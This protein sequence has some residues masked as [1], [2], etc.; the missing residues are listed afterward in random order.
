MS[1]ATIEELRAAM[2]GAQVFGKGQYIEEGQYLLETIKIFYKRTVIDGSAKESIICEFKV[3]ES[4]KPEVEIGSTRSYV[5]NL[6]NAG[7]LSRFKSCMLAL[8]GVD[9]D[10]KIPKDA[11]DATT[12]LYVALR[13]D[14]ERVRLGLP[15]N[16]MAGKRVRV[17]GMAG[18]SKKGGAVT[19]KKW[20][21]VTVKEAA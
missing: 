16:F 12:D 19:N 6:A 10:G 8:I 1:S 21:P 13:D 17:E 20:I 9:P 3:L 4:S 15:E 11:E 5:E 18:K 2:R 7:W 14:G